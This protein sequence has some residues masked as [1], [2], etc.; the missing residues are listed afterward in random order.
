[1]SMKP[2]PWRLVLGVVAGVIFFACASQEL[3]SA[4]L[5]IQ[6]EEWGKAEEFLLKA[7]TVEPN[8]PEVP[9][10]LGREIY[11]RKQEWEKMAEMF[12]RAL[13]IDP[14]RKILQGATV[15]EYVEQSRVK[16]W[17]DLYNGGV[18]LFNKY[19]TAEGEQRE[20]YL[21]KATEA[22]EIAQKI[23]PDEAQTYAILATCY[24]EGGDKE[25]AA[26]IAKKGVTLNPEDVVVNM[27]AGQILTRIGDLEGS[28]PYFQKVIEL[29]TGNTDAIRYLAQNYYDLG[30]LENA[31]KVYEQ[32][33]KLETDRKKRGDL[34]FNMG[35]LY[36]KIGEY[37]KAE[38][39]FMMAYD[40]NPDDVE[41]LVGIAQTF[42]SA[43]KWGRAEKF[44]KELIYLDPDNPE[45]YRGMARVLIRQGRS[46]EAQ[47]YY[48]KSKR[49]GN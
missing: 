19:R 40:L 29:E 18:N 28:L 6:Q 14:D 21:A 11:S 10:L 43:E 13:E 44:Y 26:E 8:N 4:K 33:I 3:T 2:F 30:Q 42:E 23:K 45:H 31:V 48:E 9:Y 38:D 49:V 35:I 5:Y 32:G 34:Y 27:T 20:E 47:Y 15:R 25:K 16:Y 1:M 17:T 39:S 24:F 22:F 46:E 12:D 36:M 7:L 37:A 41:A